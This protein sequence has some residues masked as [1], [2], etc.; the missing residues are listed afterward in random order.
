MIFISIFFR[1]FTNF[2]LGLDGKPRPVHIN[3]GK[4]NI[5]Y[6]RDTNWVKKNLINRVE[7]ISKEE[8]HIEERTGLHEREFINKV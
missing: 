6:N 8:G 5:Q 2:A 4:E 1:S 7:T 3:H